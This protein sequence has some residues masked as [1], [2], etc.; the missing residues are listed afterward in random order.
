MPDAKDEI[1]Q[2]ATPH[3]SLGHGEWHGITAGASDE[4][5]PDPQDNAGLAD[6]HSAASGGEPAD[7]LDPD[8]VAHDLSV[9]LGLGYRD[10]G[11]GSQPTDG[12]TEE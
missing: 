3:D 7:E 5:V 6:T 4:T 1:S 9:E 11:V 12:E 2:D 8:D 10:Y